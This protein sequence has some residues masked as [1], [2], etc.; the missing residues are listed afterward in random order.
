MRRIQAKRRKI[1]MGKYVQVGPNRSE[2]SN[3]E[4]KGRPRTSLHKLS[5]CFRLSVHFS[6]FVSKMDDQAPFPFANT[7][8][9]NGECPPRQAVIGSTLDACYVCPVPTPRATYTVEIVDVNSSVA[10]YWFLLSCRCDQF[11]FSRRRTTVPSCP[12]QRCTIETI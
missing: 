5:Y 12:Y 1:G 6:S 2:T 7:P 8:R 10:A 9:Y 4:L 11:C 3:S